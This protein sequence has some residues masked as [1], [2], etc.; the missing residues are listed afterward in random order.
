MFHGR[1]FTSSVHVAV[2]PLLLTELFECAVGGVKGQQFGRARPAEGL[3]Q[4]QQRRAQVEEEG[5]RGVHLDEDLGHL[6]GPYLGAAGVGLQAA[7]QPG[8]QHMARLAGALH[9]VLQRL[10]ELGVELA[11]ELQTAG[12]HSESS[13]HK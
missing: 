10:V 2:P 8:E 4:L 13:S 6:I 1:V 11:H 7:A 9:Q 12:R 5:V 3:A